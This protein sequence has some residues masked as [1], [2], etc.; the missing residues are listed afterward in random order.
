LAL[1]NSQEQ[2]EQYEPIVKNS[3]IA[4]GNLEAGRDWGFAKDYVEAMW[5]MVQQKN[6]DDFVILYN[7]TSDSRIRFNGADALSGKFESKIHIFVF[8]RQFK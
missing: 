5:L 7:Y 1:K 3:K 6:A 4:L 8:L 2:N